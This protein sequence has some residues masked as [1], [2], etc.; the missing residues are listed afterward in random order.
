MSHCD[1]IRLSALFHN[2]PSPSPPPP[3]SLSPHLLIPHRLSLGNTGYRLWCIAAFSP[4][5]YVKGAFSELW[6]IL[7][8]ERLLMPYIIAL[9]HV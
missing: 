7:S 4:S 6:G 3:P 9:D 8:R 2:L 1:L 5:S